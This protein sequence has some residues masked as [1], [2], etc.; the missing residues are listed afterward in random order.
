MDAVGRGWPETAE[1]DV[2]RTTAAAIIL[3]V[4]S[5]VVLISFI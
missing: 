5:R 2:A 4:L 3:N 1:R